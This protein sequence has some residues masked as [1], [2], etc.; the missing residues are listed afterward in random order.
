MEIRILGSLEVEENGRTVDVG[1]ARQRALLAI[2]VLHRGAVVAAERLID[3][4]YAGRPPPSAA[5]TLQAH[6]S[7]LRKAIG[8]GEELQTRGTGYI[9]DRATLDVDAD[10]FTDLLRSG[11]AALADDR[12]REAADLLETALGLWRGPPLDDMRYEGFAQP[13]IA[14]LEELHLGA[15]DDLIDA[16]LALGRHAEVVGELERL[17]AQHPLRERPRGQLMLALYR[18]GRQGDALAVYQSGRRAVVEELGLEPGRG[19]QDLERA[20]LKQDPTLDAVVSPESAVA[21]ESRQARR[22]AGA[23]VGRDGELGELIAALD[24]AMAGT[25]QLVVLSG[26]AGIGK[27]RLAE[28]LAVEAKARGANVL[29]G[30]C[31]EAGG[32]PAYWPWVQRFAP[33]F[34]APIRACCAGKS[35][36]ASPT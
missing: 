23:F 3:D 18:S 22:A 7:R 5:K 32:A 16:R 17:V 28:E 20:I 13:E 8:G 2:L 11:R 36:P 1:G 21:E 4:L 14:R 6:I 19:L 9:L 26:E 12:P 31:W 27:S 15:I 29:W 10:R 34:V 33:T 24:H 25:G 30:H 35:A